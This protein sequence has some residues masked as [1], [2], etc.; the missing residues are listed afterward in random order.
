[1]L[2]MFWFFVKLP[3]SPWLHRVF[4]REEQTPLF[5]RRCRHEC[6]AMKKVMIVAAG[7]LLVAGCSTNE[8]HTGSADV[9]SPGISGGAT[10]TP[11]GTSNDPLG[12]ASGPATPSGSSAI[13]ETPPAH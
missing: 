7:L 5:S 8:R 9:T 10:G 2:L 4:P 13:H 1:M 3:H 11:S 12:P 6:K